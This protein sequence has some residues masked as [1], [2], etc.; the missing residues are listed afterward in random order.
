MNVVLNK[1]GADKLTEIP[2]LTKITDS[3]VPYNER[4]YSR[5]DDMVEQTYVLD[6]TIEQMNKLIA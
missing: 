3:I 1:F 2:G 5:L 6:Y 4:H